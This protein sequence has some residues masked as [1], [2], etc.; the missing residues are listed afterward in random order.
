MPIV[1]MRAEFSCPLE[2]VW[3]TVTDLEHWSWRSDIRGMWSN[4]GGRSFVELSRDRWAL[5]VTQTSTSQGKSTPSAARA[6]RTTLRINARIPSLIEA[7]W[8]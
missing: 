8:S 3:R 7:L 4:A 6:V 2:R 1:K 5:L